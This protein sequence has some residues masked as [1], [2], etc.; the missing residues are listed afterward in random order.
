MDETKYGKYIVTDLKQNI[1]EAP[2]TNPVQPAGQGKGGRLLFLDSELVPGAF[3]VETAWSFPR[4][5][6]GEPRTVAEP[7]QHDY[8]EVLAMFGT[9]TDDPHDL[10]GEVEFWLGDEQHILTRSCIIFIPAGLMHCPL[11]Y[12]RVDK[13]IFTF[14]THHGKMYS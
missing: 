9:G 6:E 7:H 11:I 8:D 4:K 2:W 1:A 5:T 14:T 3:Y 13:P 12:R 10:G